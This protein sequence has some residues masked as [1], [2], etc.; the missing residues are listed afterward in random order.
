[1]QIDT[2]PLRIGKALRNAGKE[3]K[4]GAAVGRKMDGRNMNPM[5][6]V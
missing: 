2:V 1:L 6:I 4:S 3:E 5:A